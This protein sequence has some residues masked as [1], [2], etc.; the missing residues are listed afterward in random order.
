MGELTWRNGLDYQRKKMNFDMRHCSNSF[1]VMKQ[2][3]YR[4]SHTLKH[5]KKKLKKNCLTF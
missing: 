2:V 5:F 3:S 4:Q 1:L